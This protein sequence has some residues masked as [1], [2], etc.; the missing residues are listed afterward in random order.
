MC[1]NFENK[2]KIIFLQAK[3]IIQKLTPRKGKGRTEILSIS[4]K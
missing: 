2:K 1:K 3:G 4:S